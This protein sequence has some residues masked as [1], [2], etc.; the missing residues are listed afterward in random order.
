MVALACLWVALNPVAVYASGY[1]VQRTVVLA[2][3]FAILSANLYLRAQQRE[4]NVDL[5]SAALLAGL[6]IMSKEHAVLLP[7]AVVVLTP[8]VRDWNRVALGRALAYLVLSVP[9]SVWALLNRGKD[10]VGT[11]YEK[12]ASEVLSQFTTV[13]VFDFPG[14]IWVMSVSTQLLL[15]WKYMFLWLV[16]NPQWMSADLRIDFPA[17]WSGWAALAGIAGALG[18]LAVLFGAVVYW[19]RSGTRGRVGQLSAVLLF[20]AIPFLVELSVVR[21]QEPFVLY[22]SFLWM[23]AYALLLCLALSWSSAWAKGRGVFARRVYWGGVLLAC[24]SLFPMA[25]N[26]LQSFSSEEAL[27]QDVLYKLPSPD[28][29]G[30]DRIYYNL[31]GE[32][33][34]A[35]RYSEALEFSERVIVQNPRA[36]QGYLAKGTSLLA[37]ADIDG[38]SRAFD[39]ASA[40]QPPPEFLGY[41][42]F[43]RC[44]VLEAQ[45]N[46]EAIPACLRRSAKM[47]YGGAEFRLKMMGLSTTE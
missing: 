23:P 26:R 12:Y 24:L 30:A 37:L 1:L 21:V 15:F 5:L 47:G 25:Q 39:E 35:K 41:I 7:F 6:S 19:L 43:K 28:V 16:P 22:R 32:A 44:L 2:T 33:Y 11:N 20:A 3:L 4:R 18:T 46:T 13:G 14:G 10:I 27:W 38:A 36:F 34:K 17:L 40:H 8:F 29:A 42:E 9:W 31:A 45:R